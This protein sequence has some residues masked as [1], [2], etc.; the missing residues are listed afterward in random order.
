MITKNQILLFAGIFL[1]L[2]IAWQGSFY[3][4]TFSGDFKS[5]NIFLEEFDK[6]VSEDEDSCFIMGIESNYYTENFQDMTIVANESVVL[7]KKVDVSNRHGIS[8]CV[9]SEFLNSG[10]NKVTMFFGSHTLFYHVVVQNYEKTVPEFFLSA[11][12]EKVEIEINNYDGKAYA[13]VSIYVNGNLDHRVYFSGNEFSSAE[14]VK[15]QEGENEIKAEFQGIEKTLTISKEPKFHMNNIFGIAILSVLIFVLWTFV[16][17]E[18]DFAERIAFTLVSFFSIFVILFFALLVTGTLNAFNY[19]V[20]ILIAIIAI[21]IFFRKNL[22]KKDSLENVKCSEM[23]KKASPMIILLI[24]LILGSALIFN[25]FTFS[26]YGVWTSFYERQSK[27]ITE[28]E[29]IP[30]IDEFSF[31]GTKPYGYM[32]AYFYIKPGIGWLT[33]LE[34]QQSYAIIMLL[35]QIAFVASLYLFFR[36]YGL[37]KKAFLG[38]AVVLF[39][40]FVF[41]DFSFN[42]RHVISYSFLIL[43]MY[44]LRR[45][46]GVMSGVV[47][48]FCTFIQGPL[49]AIFIALSPLLIQ[50]KEQ[51]F[52]L[53]KALVIGAIIAFIF[54]IPTFLSSG[55]PSQAKYDVWGYFWSIP[56][57]GFF[58]DYLPILMLIAV[59]IAPF[60]LSGKSKFDNFSLR[61]LGMLLVYLFIQLFV[62]YRINVAATVAFALLIS[63]LFPKD[64]LKDK[65]SEYATAAFFSLSYVIMFFIILNFYTVPPS[66]SHSFNYTAD[67]SS[68]EANFLNEPYLGHP[69]IHDAQRKSSADLAVEYANEQMID[70]S[71]RF[72]KEKDPEILKEYSI[73][74]VINRSIYLDEKPV[75]DNTYKEEIE[76]QFLD[77]IYSNEFVHIHWVD[78]DKL[79]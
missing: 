3:W 42:I 12:N 66:L 23:I 5:V 71:F 64:F 39:G 24:A 50:K 78:K 41:S 20:G 44:L 29:K 17:R 76:F 47:L 18:N 14:T 67:Y 34:G 27:T 54:F 46:K 7:Q 61:V 32:S 69:F 77:K 36:S 59:F 53:V 72:L 49:Y 45:N 10:E 51:V 25:M 4:G 33:G 28:I 9:S 15:L 40:G 37:E 11:E 62:S 30:E 38:A 63:L 52:E 60:L 2:V 26:Y 35:S 73:D 1:L 68:T 13:P 55:I 43:S 19:V 70:D 16:F 31:L 65:F 22:K 58:L 6:K 21:S 79:N 75:G 48:G 74:Y 8:E 57:Y 56:L